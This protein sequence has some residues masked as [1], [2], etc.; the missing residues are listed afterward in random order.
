M[1]QPGIHDDPMAA[2][3]E[4][5]IHTEEARA[6]AIGPVPPAPV[7]RREL[8]RI[9]RELLLALGQD[10]DRPGLRDTPRRWADWWGEFIDY[11]PGRTGTV[12]EFEKVETDQMVMVGPMKVWSLCVPSRQ[13][14]NAI[15]GAKRAADVVVGDRLWTLKDGRVVPTKVVA[16]QAHQT[17]DLIEVATDGG[18]FRVTPDHPFAT[19]IGW[20]EARHL[21]GLS[22]EWT[23]PRSLCRERFDLRLGYDF[24]YVVGAVCSDGTVGDRYLS[25]VVNKE[26]FARR[27]ADALRSAG[28]KAVQ[29]LMF[30]GVDHLSIVQ[31]D[32]ENNPVRRT[33][34]AF[35]GA[36][37][38]P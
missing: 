3:R 24:G 4:E 8:Q 15:D 2:I 7:D 27:F 11:E 36:K 33:I 34:L 1:N 10:P 21:A 25:L 29:Q 23:Q 30:K 13:I 9:C 17:R 38:L 20:I 19:P 12:F 16:I 18:T 32:D 37:A 22:I 35:M 31:F 5:W 6:R 28:N 26:P 14:V